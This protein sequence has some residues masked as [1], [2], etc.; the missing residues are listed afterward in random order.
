MRTYGNGKAV[1]IADDVMCV[2]GI[3]RAN[4]AFALLQFD[5]EALANRWRQS[6]PQFRHNDWLDDHDIW[7]LPLNQE[8]NDD[9]YF[10]LDLFGVCNKEKL[11][12]DFIPKWLDGISKN[13]GHPGV[14]CTG[15]VKV[16]RGVHDADYVV[17]SQ[18][19]SEENFKQWYESE[20]AKQLREFQEH[21]SGCCTLLARMKMYT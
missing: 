2:Q 9:V 20:E 12:E 5:S 4:T 6:D 1:A 17:L 15:S 7:V 13:G 19:P 21:S 11:E 18:W 10:Q 14:S 3:W 8:L 16:W